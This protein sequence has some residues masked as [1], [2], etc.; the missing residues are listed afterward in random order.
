[1][2]YGMKEARSARVYLVILLQISMVGFVVVFTVFVLDTVMLLGI[3]MS[4]VTYHRY[5]T[6]SFCDSV[7]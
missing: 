2:I 1:M 5:Q 4:L 7:L 6:L 3:S